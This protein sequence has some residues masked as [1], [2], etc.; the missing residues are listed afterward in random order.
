MI[1]VPCS[2]EGS[3][4]KGNAEKFGDNGRMQCSCNALDSQFFSVIKPISSHDSYRFRYYLM[5]LEQFIQ[6]AM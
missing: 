4:F 2:L 1:C 5:N 6:R 3:V